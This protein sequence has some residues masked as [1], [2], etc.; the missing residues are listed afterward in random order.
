MKKN[1][2]KYP[3]FFKMCAGCS[4]KEKRDGL[5]QE[6]YFCLVRHEVVSASSDLAMTCDDFDG[7]YVEH[8]PKDQLI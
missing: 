5:K 3:G 2:S 4:K 1:F 8:L 6:D 7:L